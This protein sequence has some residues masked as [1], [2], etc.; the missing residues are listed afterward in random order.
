MATYVFSDVHGHNAPLQRLLN[1]ISPA[2]D[3]AIYTLQGGRVKNATRGLYIKG[4]KTFI[5]K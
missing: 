3:D 4:G 5:V 1:R 2:D